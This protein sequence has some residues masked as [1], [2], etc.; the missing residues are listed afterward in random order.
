MDWDEIE[1]ME[2]AN[3]KIEEEPKWIVN[4]D[5]MEDKAVVEIVENNSDE[6]QIKIEIRM[7]DWWDESVK[8]SEIINRIKNIMKEV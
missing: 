7:W 1:I 3:V 2:W 6:V 5:R 8:E 4:V